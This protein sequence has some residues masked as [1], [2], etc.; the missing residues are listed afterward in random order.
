MSDRQGFTLVEVIM[1]VLIFSLM[2]GGLMSASVVANDQ[3]TLGKYDAE[4]WVVVTYQ[5]EKL[6]A[7]GY[8]NIV[9][10]DDTIQGYPLEW[11]VSGTDPKKIELIVAKKILRGNER[12][13]EAFVTYLVDPN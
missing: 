6:I 5:M 7:I 8:D 2:M 9:T 11:I 12:R 1:A 10:G 13:S 4:V 3:L